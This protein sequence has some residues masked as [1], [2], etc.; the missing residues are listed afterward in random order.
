MASFLLL[1]VA[2]SQTSLMGGRRAGG[3]R[4]SFLNCSHFFCRFFVPRPPSTSAS[5]RRYLHCISPSQKVHVSPTLQLLCHP[6][7]KSHHDRQ[8][9]ANKA[10]PGCGVTRS[11]TQILFSLCSLQKSASVGRIM[12][13]GALPCR[14]VSRCYRSLL[15]CCSWETDFVLLAFRGLWYTTPFSNTQFGRTR[16]ATL[17]QQ[18][19]TVS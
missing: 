12:L 11:P 3:G 1:D 4:G 17:T 15:R 13:R 18:A 10:G 9:G 7:N 16:S 6:L 5:V 2:A 14:V 19:M 8:C